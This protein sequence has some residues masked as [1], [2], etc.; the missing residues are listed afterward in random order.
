M[1]TLAQ[2]R[3]RIADDL[4][5]S[6]LSS[7]IDKAINRAIKYYQGRRFWFNETTGTFTTVADQRTYGSADGLPSDI[8]EIDFLKIA[9]TSLD[10]PITPRTYSWIENIDLGNNLTG[11]PTDYALYQ[12]KVYL[13]PIPDATYTITVSY[14]QSYSEL[15]SDSDTNDWTTEA[16][17]LIEARARWWLYTRVIQDREMA[18]DAKA[19]EREAL[20]MLVQ[21]TEKMLM[22]GT[23]TPMAW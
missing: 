11:E 7:Q 10:D 20:K 9:L 14:Q 2:M 3:S 21:R 6:D 23:L 5:R 18:A 17:D 13:Y 4:D 19:E 15:S 12:E 22:K 16:E 8:V 1:S